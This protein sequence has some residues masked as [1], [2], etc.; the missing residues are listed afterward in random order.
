MIANAI[1][2]KQPQKYQPQLK[3]NYLLCIQRENSSFFAQIPDSA[4]QIETEKFLL[5]LDF[6]KCNTSASEEKYCILLNSGFW[7]FFVSVTNSRTKLPQTFLFIKSFLHRVCCCSILIPSSRSRDI[8]LLASSFS[9]FSR[10]SII[11]RTH[12]SKVM[13]RQD[14]MLMSRSRQSGR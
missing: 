8:N 13:P 14:I 6:M 4:Q 10:E 7:C 5:N 1:A 9:L 11:T 3:R 12:S 2:R